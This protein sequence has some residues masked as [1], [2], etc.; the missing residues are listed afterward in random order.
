MTRDEVE[1]FG[2]SRQQVAVL[3]NVLGADRW[4]MI[5]PDRLPCSLE[6]LVGSLSSD[7]YE[8]WEAGK[9]EVRDRDG[10]VLAAADVADWRTREP[11]SFVE[12]A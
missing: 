2:A 4:L 7:S 3:C 6:T 12:R 1:Q 5:E 10:T 11:L 8:L 9:L